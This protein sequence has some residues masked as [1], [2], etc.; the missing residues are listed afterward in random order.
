M[1]RNYCLVYLS[2]IDLNSKFTSLWQRKCAQRFL[3]IIGKYDQD[4]ILNMAI[5]QLVIYCNFF[6]YYKFSI[7]DKP[8]YYLH[9][10]LTNSCCFV[11]SHSANNM[12]MD[13]TIPNLHIFTL[14]VQ[15]K[16]RYIINTKDSE[17]KMVKQL[18]IN[19]CDNTNGSHFCYT[20]VK[21]HRCSV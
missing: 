9:D 20:G 19:L 6:V 17:S 21:Y 13:W 7:Y 18:I 3:L 10:Q 15:E 16:L 2:W 14:N 11:L 5:Y 1:S 12:N 4:E 8:T